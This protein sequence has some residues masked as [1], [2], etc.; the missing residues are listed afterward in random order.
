M[1]ISNSVHFGNDV[2]ELNIDDENN[3]NSRKA[4]S[5]SK[6]VEN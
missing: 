1:I 6:S 3:C 4:F 5:A 2:L